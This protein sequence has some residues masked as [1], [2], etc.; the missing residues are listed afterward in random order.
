MGFS[1]LIDI[2]GSTLIG[3]FI[4]LILFR[5]NDSTIESH[6][7]NSGELLV[8]SNLVEVVELLEHD[9]RKIAYC[10]DWDKIP[11]PN[12]AI[13]SATSSSISFLTDVAISEAVQTGDGIVDTLK[14]WIGSPTEASVLGTPNPKDRLL[15]RQVNSDPPLTAN[16]GVTQFNLLYFNSFGTQIT[17]MP[18][19]PPLGIITMQIDITVENTAAYGDE[20]EEDVYSKDRSAFYRQIRLAAPSIGIR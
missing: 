4:M 10:E 3:G 14:Y 16:L 7:L 8:Q 5:M 2:L 11:R 1:T 19:S 15:Y 18:S 12:E 17:T 6:Y 20:Q 13:L 9:L